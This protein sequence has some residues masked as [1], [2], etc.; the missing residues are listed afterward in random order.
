[1]EFI[2]FLAL[3][4]LLGAAIMTGLLILVKVMPGDGKAVP[5]P[6]GST[7]ER[8]PSYDT[9]APKRKAAFRIGWVM[10]VWLGIL[11]IAEIY[12]GLVLESTSL[13]LV[14]NILEAAS[15]LY[16]FMHIKTVWSSEEAH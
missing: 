11:T 14:V 9:L 2:A 4:L 6:A 16:V 12:T 1:M 10:L 13:L 5:A 15:I 7:A 8:G 3:P